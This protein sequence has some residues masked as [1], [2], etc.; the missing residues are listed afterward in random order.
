MMSTQQQGGMQKYNSENRNCRENAYL[1]SI[2]LTD[3]NIYAR[4]HKAPLLIV[5]AMSR[6]S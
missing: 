1:I 2:D 4:S 3:T 5:Y 6:K